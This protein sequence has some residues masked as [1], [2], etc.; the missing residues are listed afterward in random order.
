MHEVNNTSKVYVSQ[1][2]DAVQQ[3]KMSHIWFTG[4]HTKWSVILV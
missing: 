3:Q 1:H 2:I 4:D